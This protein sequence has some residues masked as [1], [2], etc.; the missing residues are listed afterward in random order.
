MRRLISGAAALACLLLAILVQGRAQEQ[1]SRMDGYSDQATLLLQEPETYQN[2]ALE[3][4]GWQ[5]E[6]EL[7]WWGEAGQQRFAGAQGYEAAVTAIAFTGST[8][9]LFPG[10][11][12]LQDTDRTGCLLD[13]KA[14]WELFGS[15]RVL[16]ETVSREGGS[17]VVRGVLSFWEGLV[18]VPAGEETQD[19]PLDCLTAPLGG[20][21]LRQAAELL[22]QG[23]HVGSLLRMDFY[24]N[25]SWVKELVPGKW[26]D[27]EGWGRSLK[28]KEQEWRLL[29]N[30]R[31]KIPQLLQYT[32]CRRYYG[33]QGGFAVLLFGFLVLIHLTFF[34]KGWIIDKKFRR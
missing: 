22:E 26:S 3:Q 33:Y 2:A 21:E 10:G 16:G 14:A 23:G 11:P 30:S 34:Q 17:W 32:A 8:Q 24:Q 27:F 28:Q 4:E 15:D 12:V 6:T 29:T 19:I 9:L 20:R 5:E 13:Q 18:V 31:K 1:K 7:V 25:L